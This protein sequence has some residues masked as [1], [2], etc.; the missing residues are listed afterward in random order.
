MR[1]GLATF[2]AHICH[3][4][5][6]CPQLYHT[7]VLCLIDCSVANPLFSWTRLNLCVGV[8]GGERRLSPIIYLFIHWFV[9]FGGRIVPPESEQ[10]IQ[11]PRVTEWCL[12]QHQHSRKGCKKCASSYHLSSLLYWQPIFL[13]MGRQFSANSLEG[14]VGIWIEVLIYPLPSGVVGTPILQMLLRRK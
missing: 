6:H 3:I 13:L 12:T 10:V 8:G 2:H 11:T 1:L 7:Y 4:T 5:C 14:E 9:S